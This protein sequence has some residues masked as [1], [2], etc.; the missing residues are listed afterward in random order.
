MRSK[1][2]S[3]TSTRSFNRLVVHPLDLFEQCLTL[4][5]ACL[6]LLNYLGEKTRKAFT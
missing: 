6:S 2:S 3:T 1:S 4:V 5:L